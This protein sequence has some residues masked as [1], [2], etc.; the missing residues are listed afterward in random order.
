MIDNQVV[1]ITGGSRGIGAGLVKAFFDQAYRVVL[2]Y[3]HSEDAACDLQSALGADDKNMLL[4]KADVSTTEGRQQLIAKTLDHFG[5][6]G[7][8][9]NNAGI[10]A[11][12]S[13]LKGTEAEFDTVL[14]TNLKGPVFLSQACAKLMIEH[15]IPGSII[16]IASVS[17]HM[18]NAPTS[19]AAAKAGLL[20]AT[21]TMALKLG[22]YGIRANTI[23]PGGIQSEMNRRIWQDDPQRWE[24]LTATVPLRRGGKPSDIASAAVYLASDDSCYMTGA[25]M[26]V[27]GGWLL[28]PVW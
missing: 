22:A 10:V 21:K 1:I 16:N 17:A 20:A 23:T 2:N 11:R 5:V 3:R 24:A 25:E 12:G 18:P 4:V 9:V 7:V 13:F 26:V 27:D 15:K 14:N 19:Y 8:L 6:M 28:K